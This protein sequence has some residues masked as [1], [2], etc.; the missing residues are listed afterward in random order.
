M[1]QINLE[2]LLVVHSAQ[3]PSTQRKRKMAGSFTQIL[4]ALSEQ[5]LER[6]QAATLGVHSFGQRV[7][8]VHLVLEQ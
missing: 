8:Q 3:P 4:H 7:P 2:S 5:R 1:N 6:V